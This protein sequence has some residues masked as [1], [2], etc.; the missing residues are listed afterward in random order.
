MLWDRWEYSHLA[1]AIAYVFTFDL[2]TSMISLPG[3]RRAPTLRMTAANLVG[4]LGGG[5]LI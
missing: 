5:S 3:L 2:D 1:R 4:S